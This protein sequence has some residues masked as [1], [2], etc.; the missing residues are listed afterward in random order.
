MTPF[1]LIPGL[2]ANS[3]VFAAAAEALWPYGPVTIA[4]HLKGEG[5]AGI[6][7]NILADAPPKFALAG[8]SFGGYLAFE[9]LR[10]APDRVLMLALIDT[11]ARPDTLEARENRERRIALTEEGRFPSVISQSFA[12]SVH[13][14]NVNEADLAAAHAA[15]S[16][17]NGP[18]LY[19][20]H[21]KAIIDRPDS[22]PL[23]SVI[24]VPTII[25]VGEEDQITPLDVAREMHARIN[26]SRLFIIPQAGHMA[27]L[28]QPQAVNDAL[29]DW[30]TS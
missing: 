25:I 29:V 5:M 7:A 14:D 24:R 28:E 23:L 2:N 22:R 17:A 16:R 27:L 3:Y 10:Q 1:L 6:A 21:Q 15:M 11:S 18:E 20:R 12:G 13:P 26:L 19:V 8:F 9:V 4:N 30:A